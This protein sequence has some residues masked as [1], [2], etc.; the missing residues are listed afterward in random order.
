[1]RVRFL[2]AAGEEFSNAVS[3]YDSQKEGLGDEFVDEVWRTI[4]RIVNHPLAWQ[5]LSAR[6]RRCLT[7]RFPYGVIYQVRSDSILIIAVMHLRR[8]PESWRGRVAAE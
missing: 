6:T 2:A 4:S 5:R 1:M 7:R 3:Y 8:H